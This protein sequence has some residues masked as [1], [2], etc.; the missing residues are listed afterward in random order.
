[1]HKQASFIPFARFRLEEYDYDDES[2]T[3]GF[4]VD[5]VRNG[6]A[7][8]GKV[9]LTAYHKRSGK[10]RTKAEIW[11]S[12]WENVLVCSRIRRQDG[13]VNCHKLRVQVDCLLF[14][15][16]AVGDQCSDM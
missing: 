15:D 6:G 16:R 5:R 8:E 10:V 9:R 4:Q 3:V 13:W 2:G 12:N 11:H 1:M 7:G 14:T